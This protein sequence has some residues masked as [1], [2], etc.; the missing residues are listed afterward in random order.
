MKGFYVLRM[1]G[2]DCLL[3]G[4]LCRGVCAC[5]ALVGRR[6]AGRIFHFVDGR[7]FWLAV[8]SIANDDAAEQGVVYGPGAGRRERSASLLWAE[9]LEVD[10]RSH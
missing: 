4:R 2:D 5:A 9:P 7:E 3:C 8:F 6:I 1:F 10:V